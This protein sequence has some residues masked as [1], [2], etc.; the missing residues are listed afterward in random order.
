MAIAYRRM[1]DYKLEQQNFE[2]Y[3]KYATKEDPETIAYAKECIDECKKLLFM[4]GKRTSE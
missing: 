4:K 2:L 3:L 1:K